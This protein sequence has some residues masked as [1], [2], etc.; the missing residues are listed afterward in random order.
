MSSA[1]FP[2]RSCARVADEEACEQ[3]LRHFVVESLLEERQ[4]WRAQHDLDILTPRHEFHD[5]RR[6]LGIVLE[7]RGEV[8]INDVEDLGFARSRR[9]LIR[10]APR[11]RR[12]TCTTDHRDREPC[13]PHDEA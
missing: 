9:E 6:T 3:E 1:R 13:E 10:W 2:A 7:R 12:R 5:L 8:A 11:P 4:R